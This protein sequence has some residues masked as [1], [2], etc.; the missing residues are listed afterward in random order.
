MALCIHEQNKHVFEHS[1]NLRYPAKKKKLGWL[2]D[3]PID[4][5]PLKD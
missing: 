3:N 1:A 5:F 2:L 4:T